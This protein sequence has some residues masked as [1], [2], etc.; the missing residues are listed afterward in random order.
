MAG[1]ADSA[2]KRGAARSAA[3]FLNARGTRMDGHR[4]ICMLSALLLGCLPFARGFAPPVAGSIA[5]FSGVRIQTQ[6]NGLRAP[7]D[8]RGSLY[9]R[10]TPPAME[11]TGGAASKAP[12]S[13]RGAGFFS[14]AARRFSAVSMALATA[15]LLFGAKPAMAS[16]DWFSSME[17]DTSAVTSSSEVVAER[18]LKDPRIS[19][20]SSTPTSARS[21]EDGDGSYLD[22]ASA[23]AT[24]GAAAAAARAPKDAWKSAAA[25]GWHRVTRQELMAVKPHV[26]VQRMPG[27]KLGAVAIRSMLKSLAAMLMTFS[28]VKLFFRRRDHH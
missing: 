11:L 6:L 3:H 9:M 21:T 26:L 15:V 1:H 18:E 28:S 17:Y 7:R 20:P 12:A 13:A 5:G 22:R 24:K 19:G 14:G 27:Y 4:R 25:A 8:F 10:S 16:G 2:E 23:A